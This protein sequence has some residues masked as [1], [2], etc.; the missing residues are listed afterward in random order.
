MYVHRY[1]R[2]HAPIRGPVLLVATLLGVV[3]VVGPAPSPASAGVPAPN[4]NTFED[5]APNPSDGLITLRES[6]S[7]A[8]AD[9]GLPSTLTV[10]SGVYELTLLRQRQRGQQQ[11]HR[12]PRPGGR[13]DHP[14]DVV[15]SDDPAD[16]P[17]PARDRQPER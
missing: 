3:T 6:L 8:N 10:P 2:P 7:A 4:A 16:L 12:R 1:G 13:R 9:G 17:G 15:R 11:R 5:L 14:A